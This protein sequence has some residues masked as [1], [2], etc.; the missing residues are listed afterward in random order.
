MALVRK[1]P[2]CDT[3]NPDEGEYLRKCSNYDTCGYCR[4]ATIT[5]GVCDDCGAVDPTPVV[6]DHSTTG[7]VVE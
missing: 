5:S 6:L 2:T 4:H 3:S 7:A 1:C